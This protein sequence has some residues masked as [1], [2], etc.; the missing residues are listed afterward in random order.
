MKEGDPMRKGQEQMTELRVFR[1]DPEKD[2]KPAYQSYKVPAVGSVLDGLNYVLEHYDSSLS[3]RYGCWGPGYERCGA[4]AMLINGAPGF[5]C[6]IP[7]QPTVMTVE[8][9]PK[10][11]V[12]K[13]LTI[14][15][16]KEQKAQRKK[17]KAVSRISIDV[18][19][20]I[21][22]RD[23][24]LLCPMNVMQMNKTER[25]G[26]AMVAD[27]DSCCGFTCKMCVAYCPQGAIRLELVK[28]EAGKK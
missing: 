22:C 12:I 8:P 27:P 18:K 14:D 26:K 4:C 3:F 16:D 15:F 10:F 5:S 7:L 9:H 13:D 21:G 24:V 19:K 17:I 20:C 1:Y 11:E 28:R 2:K 23:C 6:K 25:K